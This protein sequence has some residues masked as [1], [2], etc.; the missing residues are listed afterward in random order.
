MTLTVTPGGAS[1]D[2]MLSLAA[3][4]AHCTAFGHTM[5]ASDAA[6]E[7]VLRKMTLFI[8]GFGIRSR[9]VSYAWPGQRTSATQSQVFPRTGATRADG[10]A[11]DSTT[12]PK[13]IEM[14][15]AEA[16]VYELSN[17]GV[18]QAAY[19]DPKQL[20]IVFEKMGDFETKYAEPKSVLENRPMLSIIADILAELLVPERKGKTSLLLAVGRG[21]TDWE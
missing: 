11:I 19:A 14:A 1:D 5:S 2:S 8:A 12:I 7:V 21:D 20:M 13:E 9:T 10:S 6:V 18:L 3:F 15:I 16:A 4:Q 17:P